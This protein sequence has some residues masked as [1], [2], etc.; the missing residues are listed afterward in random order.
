MWQY[1]EGMVLIIALL[2][3]ALMSALIIITMRNSQLELKMTQ[4]YQER[5]QASLAAENA[6]HEA[7]KSLQNN[8]R[9]TEGK[10]KNG[11]FQ[12]ELL[13][14][15]DCKKNYL[16]NSLGQFIQAKVNISAEYQLP[17]LNCSGSPKQL[18]WRT[19]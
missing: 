15:K 11:T 19:H 7:K 17:D 2:F 10:T 9:I 14:K 5:L 13:S 16:I 1:G 4:H 3:L 12:I 18:W 6:L 8:E